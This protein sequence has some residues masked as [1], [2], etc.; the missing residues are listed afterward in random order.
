MSWRKTVQYVQVRSYNPFIQLQLFIRNPI[1]MLQS[2]LE[3]PVDNILSLA[4]T[5]SLNNSL[6]RHDPEL[7][8]QG[9][10][11]I[12]L[13]EVILPQLWESICY[14]FSSRKIKR[15]MG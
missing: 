8:Q 2:T 7:L 1:A 4:T 10:L 15:A 9:E 5:Y 3:N 11:V 14:Q 6:W 12:Y 13:H